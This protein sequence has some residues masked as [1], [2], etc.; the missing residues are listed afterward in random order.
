MNSQQKV[1]K[2]FD[3]RVIFMVTEINLDKVSGGQIVE[4]SEHKFVLMPPEAKIYETKEE[5]EKAENE[6]LKNKLPKKPRQRRNTTIYQE[7]REKLEQAYRKD[8][9]NDVFKN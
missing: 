1:D 2:N 9:K 7:Q 4:T 6:I 3:R 5:A 8:A